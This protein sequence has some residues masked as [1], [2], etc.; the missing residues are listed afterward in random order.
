MPL[1]RKLAAIAGLAALI[2]IVAASVTWSR[3]PE[4]RVLFANLS[5]KDGGAVI[6]SLS[7]LNVPYRFSSGGAAIMVPEDRVHD[8]RLKLASQGLPR[9]GTVGFELLEKQKFGVTQFQERLN[10]QRGLE[11]ELSRSIQSLAAVRNARVHLALPAQ[12][13]FLR[14][15]HKPSASVLLELHPGRA[16]DRAQVAG[17]VHLVAS[18]VPELAT[19]QVSVIDQTGSLL[20][21]NGEGLANGLD[22]SQL[23][24]VRRMESEFSQRVLDIVEPMVGAGNV[25]AQVTADIDFTQSESTAEQ[26]RP[27]Q[28]SEP[29]AVRS[30]QVVESSDG[31]AASAQGVPGALSNQPPAAATAPVNGP[32]QPTEAAPP[33]SGSAAAAR[34]EAVTNF[35][36][37][38]TVRV[39]RN[40][41][42]T[43]RRLSAAIVVNHRRE[44]DEAGKV[45]LT[46]LAP[47][48]LEN[49]NALVREAMGFNKER[50]DSLNI[51]NAPFTEAEVPKEAPLELW[52]RPE[53][54]A[55]ARDIGKQL[56]LVLLGLI[57]IFAL[58]RPVLKALARP[59][60]PASKLAE[61]VD[62]ALQLPVPG[63]AATQ[64]AQANLR[65]ED[66]L[67][68]AR[69]NPAAVATVVR[70]WVAT[71]S[72]GA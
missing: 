33:R 60:A 7:Q 65:Q 18:S 26:Y 25:R 8:A 30:Q 56:G 70:S 68:I 16:L 61:R 43:I 11:G 54:I 12:N 34:R 72:K 9:G 37:D 38:K 15:Q 22:S 55:L 28:G 53:N 27:N 45:T 44:V 36:V 49:I 3:Q 46:P 41:S 50:G 66:I 32:A 52:Q 14:E 21:T 29:A 62:D 58:I 47:G 20:S 42:G 48:D 35:E 19:K 39:T 71:E 51:V 63:V 2:A 59:P 67:K 17:I 4:Y 64:A 5:D 31:A 13:G 10:F 40:A 23:N 6:A 69:D 1:R 24:Y 57:V